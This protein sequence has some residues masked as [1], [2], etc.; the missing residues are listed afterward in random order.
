MTAPNVVGFTG[1]RRGPTEDDWTQLEDFVT[2]LLMSVKTR[3]V[4][5]IGFAAITKAHDN[6]VITDWMILPGYNMHEFVAATHYLSA[7]ITQEQLSHPDI[8]G[9]A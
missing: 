2:T 1:N 6:P 3:N 4:G 9:A 8:D 7:A 5:A